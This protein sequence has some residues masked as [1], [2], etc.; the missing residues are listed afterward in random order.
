[1]KASIFC[2]VFT[3][4]FLIYNQSS[5][6]TLYFPTQ[7]NWDTVAPASLGWCN[8]Y[9][10]TLFTYLNSNKTKAFVL[11]KDGKIA[12]EKYFGGFTKDSVW[13][14]A[15]AG[16]SLTSF[17]IG[18]AQQ[19]GL[20]SINDSTVQY[21]GSGFTSCAASDENEITIRHQLTMTTGLDDGVPDNHCTLDSCLIYKAQAGSRWAYHNAPYTLLDSV[22]EVATGQS[23][24][25][26]L[27]SKLNATGI[28][29]VFLPS[30]YN[31]IFYSKPRSMARFG[32]L[33]NAG[34][35]WDGNIIMTDTGY[36]NQMTSTSQALNA[37]Y[38]Y[39]WW[40][41]GKSSYMLPQT[42]FTFQG[43]LFPNAPSDMYAALG[44]NGQIIN[45]VPSQ[46]LVVI[47]MGETASAGN[48][49][50][51]AFNDSIW[52]LLNQ[53][54]CNAGSIQSISASD[55]ELYPNPTKTTAVLKS[56]QGI[57]KL[58]ICSVTG[59]VMQ[60]FNKVPTTFVLPKLPAGVYFL[61]A[62]IYKSVFNFRFIC[63]ED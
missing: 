48:S 29:G 25:G 49:V 63:V 52:G 9:I 22:M 43:M 3:V 21:L 20:M 2:L 8:Q 30:G 50:P 51:T 57:D 27:F 18:I 37:S 12:I 61:K 7:N 44:K 28:S 17:M 26:Y 38:G 34:G 6:Q 39:L 33:M 15:S 32:L 1:M 58:E 24:N 5:A 11:L 41:N 35:V 54:I 16:K 13:Y 46:N 14:W 31:H 55:F 56:K 23:L 42:Q 36:F 40:L 4:Q 59:E 62:Y 10:D 53:I 47:R 19:E 45:V 60:T